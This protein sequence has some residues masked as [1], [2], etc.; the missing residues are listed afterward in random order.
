[1][2]QKTSRRNFI[3]QAA[4]AGLAVGIG[5]SRFIVGC[6]GNQYDLIISKGMIYDGSGGDPFQADIGIRGDRI[7]AIGDLTSAQSEFFIF[8]E[9]LAVSPGFIDAHSHTDTGLLV[10]PNAE[11]K[12]RQGVT[13]EV[14]GNCGSSPFPLMGDSGDR[15][16]KRLKERYEIDVDW[17]DCDG[18]LSRLERN[19]ISVNYVTFIGHSDVREAVMGPDNRPPTNDELEKMKR[20][21]HEAVEQGAFGLSTGLEYTPGSFAETDE[22]VELCKVAANAGGLYA[23]HMRNEDVRVIEAIE[24]TLHIARES[25]ISVEIAHLKANQKRNWNKLPRIL[26]LLQQASDAGINVHADRYAYPAWST[27]LQIMFPLWSRE[28]ETADF[29]ERLKDNAQWKKIREFVSDKINAMG[30]WESVMISRVKSEEKR[31]YQGKTVARLA[32]DD[33]KNPYTFARQLLIDEDGEVGIVGFGM[34]AENTEKVLAFPLTMV[35]SDGS[36]LAVEGPL[37]E[38][39]PHPRNYGCFPRYL[40]H[41]IRERGILPLN[42]AIRR[43][44]SMPAEK[45]MI[46]DRGILAKGKFAD[47]TIFNPDSVIDK[48]TFT[49]PH[50]YPEGIDYVI[51]NGQIV[52][53]K[54]QHSGKHPGQILRNV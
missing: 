48:A 31:H 32:K 15:F 6:A 7:A 52:I 54:G 17:T 47:I 50:Q 5:G 13:T 44:T 49:D 12:I 42:E 28:G 14:S 37:S 38:G 39:N 36:A 45:F 51:V 10:N 43:I 29:I 19:G 8:A 34:S 30:S 22:I 9:G 2:T 1:M 11:S 41:Y 18:F 23:T 35:G 24:E 25:A 20:I 4:A 33:G 3:K 27:T 46:K 21:V 16:K 26:E 40:G 53:G